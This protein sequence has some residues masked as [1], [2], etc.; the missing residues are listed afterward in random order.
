MLPSQPSASFRHPSH[1]R[2]FHVGPFHIEWKHRLSPALPLALLIAGACQAPSNGA[3]D[4]PDGAAGNQAQAMV[5]ARPAPGSQQ[6]GVRGPMDPAVGAWDPAVSVQDPAAG[7]PPNPVKDPTQ[8]FMP[9][10]IVEPEPGLVDV[11][12]ETTF[13]ELQTSVRAARAMNADEAL[14][15]YPAGLTDG[16]S[17]DPATS[18][19]LDRIQASAL[20]LNDGELEVFG[21]KGLVISPRRQFPT[22]LR[23]LGAIYMEHLPLYVSADT[24]LEAV[25]TSYDEI[26]L[27]FEEQILIADLNALLETMRG[28]LPDA[29]WDATTKA[30][31]DLYLAV[32]TSLLKGQTVAPVAGGDA[33]QIESFVAQATAANG[34]AT[35]TL[36][37]KPRMLDFSQ[38]TPRG[39]YTGRGPELERY[40]RAMMWLGRV[41]LRLIETL[42][43]GQQVFRP[44]QY[45]A[46]LLLAELVAADRTRW[47]RIDET[48]R[49]F[50]GESDYMVVP[51]V[52]TLIE[53]LGGLDAAKQAPK[54]DVVAAIVAGDYGAQQIA[55]HLVVNDTPGMTLPLN[56]SFLVF[57]QRYI[58]DSHV[59]SSVTYD[60]VGRMMP[61]PLDAA[62]AAL[63]NNQALSLLEP[64]LER[65]ER[66]PGALAGMRVIVDGHGDDFWDANFYNLWMSALRALSP[67][68]DASPE[69]MPEIA[70][71]EAFGLRMLNSQLGSWAQ[72]RHDTLLYAKQSYTGQPACEFPDVYVDPYPAFFRALERYA[73]Q[74]QRIVQLAE[75]APQ[76]NDG[77]VMRLATYFDALASTSGTLAEMA[78]FQQRGEPFSEAHMAFINRSVRV[79]TMAAGCT[80]VE[81]PDGWYADLFFDADSSLAADPTI[82]DVHTQ[83]ADEAGN[84]VGK[85]LHVGTGLPRMM[86]ISIDTCDGPKA[87][88]G[89]AYAYHERITEDF[90]RLTD[91]EWA[92]DLRNAQPEEV[93]W[94]TSILG[95]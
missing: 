52:A 42:P 24:L 30:D 16:L 31:A 54:E 84:I 2:A 7:V 41:D 47:E 79:E 65:V 55:S 43:N 87:Y 53:D 56:R 68:S 32:A 27:A 15:A 21:D 14:S 80:T 35:P 49:T 85:I 5:P 18:A 91:E 11:D 8:P 70:T 67:P 29:T 66:Y 76:A 74:G 58:V 93:P 6:P 37:G 61:S 10:D 72:L 4:V 23:G 71:T 22:F 86:V 3:P 73:E 94:M 78:E 88:V 26:L 46:T 82:A 39:H 1:P 40:F 92:A 33:E 89:L 12:Q 59:F 81:V 34:I 50:V 48:I 38:F 13:K 75:G 44:E 19:H 63:G 51:E 64:E 17:Y 9:E 95:K 28:Q 83:P 25:H 36:F 57:G 45:Q 62:F 69:G 20:A 90:K 77:F 60:R